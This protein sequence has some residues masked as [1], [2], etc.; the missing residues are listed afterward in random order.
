MINERFLR[1]PSPVVLKSDRRGANH[2]NVIRNCT[3]VSL[4]ANNYDI[5]QLASAAMTVLF[6]PKTE[7]M[8]KMLSGLRHE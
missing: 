5:V 7:L 6:K 2:Q 4:L 8:K 3:I 1:R